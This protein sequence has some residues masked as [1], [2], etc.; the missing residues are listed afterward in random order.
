MA[1]FIAEDR[2]SVPADKAGVLLG[3]RP[4]LGYVNLR[5]DP[6]EQR[7][8]EAVEGVLGVGLPLEPNTVS[9]AREMAALWLGPDEWLVVTPPDQET[10]LAQAL[11]DPLR[12]M[13][14]SGTD[15]TG[16]QTLVN[17][18]GPRVRDLLAKGCSLDLHPRVFVPGRCAQ[19][20]L[21]KATVV[22]WR[23]DGTPSYNVIV[24]RTYAD[25]LARW[26]E[27]AAQ[28]YGLA[29]QPGSADQ[30]QSGSVKD[31]S[32]GGVVRT[33]DMGNS[34]SG[35]WVTHFTRHRT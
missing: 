9:V 8:L 33:G 1:Q 22:I 6:A 7:F 4:L 14:A 28:E 18:G 27:D 2:A 13:F 35:T 16:G 24:R 20:M 10:G 23:P 34:C 30:K 15:V 19:T 12:E 26:L 21:A 25:Y 5:G 29:M 32:V 3:E 17:L 11:A 31:L